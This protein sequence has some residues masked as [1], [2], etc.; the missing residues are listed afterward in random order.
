MNDITPDLEETLSIDCHLVDNVDNCNGFLSSDQNFKLLTFNIRSIQQNFDAFQVTLK[1]INIDFE[2]LVLTECWLNEYTIIPHLPGYTASRTHKFINKSGGVVV[3]VNDR[4]NA[5]VVESSCEDCNCLEIRIG[6]DALVMGI[7]RSPSFTNA[8]HFL[9]SLDKILHNARGIRDVFI[10]GDINIDIGSESLNEQSSNYVSLLAQHQLLPAITKPTRGD[11]CLDHCFVKCP[12]HTL[13]VVCTADITDHYICM[14]GTKIGQKKPIAKR[15]RLKTDNRAIAEE[16]RIADWASVQNCSDVNEATCIFNNIITSAIKK[17]TNQIQITRSNFNLKPWITPGL[18]RCQ[19]H[20]DK[21]HLQAKK[22][23]SNEVIQISY[24]RYRNY[25]YSLLRKLKTDYENQTLANNKKDPKKLWRTIKEICHLNKP[26]SPNV[27]LCN[28]KPDPVSSLN[29]C[30]EFFASVGKKLAHRTLDK[31]STTEASL[32]ATVKMPFTKSGSFFMTP[33]DEDEV[34]KLIADMKP[35]S[36][37]G[38][39][40]CTPKLIKQMREVLLGPITHIFN[41]SL[42]S[43]TFPESWKTAIVTPIL[44]SG[45]KSNPSNYRPI[46]LLTIFAKLLEKLVNKRMLS[47]LEKNEMLPERQFG[48]RRGKSTE[49]AVT[50]VDGIISQALDENKHCLGIFIDLAK[51]FDTVSI[52]ILLKKLYC[53]GFRGLSQSWFKSYLTGRSQCTRVN[54]IVSENL[55]VEFGVPQGSILGPTL[56]IVYMSDL[57]HL[58]ANGAEIICYADDTALLFRGKTWDETFKKA[59][60]GMASVMDW[61]QINLLTLNVE[62]TKYLAFHKT[63]ATQLLTSKVLKL[64]KCAQGEQST[65]CD[66]PQIERTDKIKYLGIIVDENLSYRHHIAALSARVRKT[67]YVMKALRLSAKKD[68]LIMV[69]KALCQSLLLYCLK[70]WGGAPKTTLIE[71][72]RAQRMVLKVMLGKP[73]RFST[74]LLYKECNV[75]RVR[76]LFIARAVI[77]IHKSFLEAPDY[78]SR[79]KMRVHKVKVPPTHSTFAKRHPYFL[80]PRIYNAICR[81]VDLSNASIKEAKRTVESWLLKQDYD[82]T[83]N[84]FDFQRL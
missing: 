72:E 51:A 42:S 23:P 47:F 84:L 79:R 65:V 7:Y 50:L 31:I 21:L 83:E 33:T 34:G 25:L 44:K 27:Q 10:T 1:R 20:R 68:T 45:D 53:L 61:L 29:C 71:L 48:F 5:T 22:N 70:V 32:A 63:R 2:I 36:A 60:S 62:K 57:L 39:D 76:Q 82:Q 11:A 3:Y 19:K 28:T 73:F 56:F 38:M 54:E 69:Y 12:T 81:K 26:K 75:L 40:Q 58:S 30:N 17:N 43:G 16:L 4:L 49:D 77:A 15:S 55:P 9:D 14:V 78:E 59:Q 66:C 80:L 74:N 64:H 37:P 8:N 13:G 35:D 24:K 46:S 18:I 67:A 41:L 52:P 6:H